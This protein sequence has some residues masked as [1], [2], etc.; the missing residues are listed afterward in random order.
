MILVVG[1][2]ASGKREYVMREYG[3]RSDQIAD[4]IL[5]DRPVVYS[6]Q[7]CIKNDPANCMDLLPQLLEKEIIICNEVGSGII[8]ISEDDRYWRE[9]TG[10]LCNA[11]AQRANRVVRVICGIPLTIKNE[12]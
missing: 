6:I 11:L 4:G 9:A 2:M 3:Y 1:G 12:Q 5:D 10:R 8:P 7:D